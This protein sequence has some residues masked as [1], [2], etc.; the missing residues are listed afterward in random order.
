[1]YIYTAVSWYSNDFGMLKNEKKKKFS[2]ISITSK[3][4]EKWGLFLHSC[5]IKS[6]DTFLLGADNTEQNAKVKAKQQT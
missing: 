6:R 2:F 1:M 3:K 4:L 5:H